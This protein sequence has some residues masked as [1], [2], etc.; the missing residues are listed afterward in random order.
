MVSFYFQSHLQC[1]KFSTSTY[2]RNLGGFQY[3][4]NQIHVFKWLAQLLEP[5]SS[6]SVTWNMWP[7]RLQNFCLNEESAW[8]GGPLFGI[9]SICWLLD[10]CINLHDF[11]LLN[12]SDYLKYY[13]VSGIF[14]NPVGRG[15]FTA[16]FHVDY[17]VKSP[18]IFIAE[19]TMKSVEVVWSLIK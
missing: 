9:V 15:S 10:L 13:V 12:S 18:D 14:I 17:L 1:S 6:H 8:K 4:T 3:I 11:R 2:E 19:N 7:F 16:F 5:K